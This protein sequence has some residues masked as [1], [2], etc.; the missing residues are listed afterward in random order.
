MTRTTCYL[1]FRFHSYVPGACAFS[2]NV[3]ELDLVTEATFM[4]ERIRPITPNRIGIVLWRMFSPYAKYYSCVFLC[5]EH[6]LSHFCLCNRCCV[7]VVYPLL[8]AN[9]V[10]NFPAAVEAS[11]VRKPTTRK[12]AA[13]FSQ[14]RTTNRLKC[15]VYHLFHVLLF[16]PVCFLLKRRSSVYRP[17][18]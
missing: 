11:E 13:G 15:R 4:S 2:N 5:L 8:A 17:R 18:N 3:L 16:F 14:P 9:L 7:I 6:F 1:S 10:R 12:T